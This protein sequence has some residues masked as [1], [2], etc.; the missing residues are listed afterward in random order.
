MTKNPVKVES[1]IL[2]VLKCKYRATSITAKKPATILEL[3][4]VVF[5]IWKLSVIIIN[6]LIN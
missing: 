6:K 2:E 5:K 4:I 3:L 1:T